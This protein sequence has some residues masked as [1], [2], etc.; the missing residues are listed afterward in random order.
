MPYFPA[1][2]ESRETELERS[3]LI[4]FFKEQSDSSYQVIFKMF[5]PFT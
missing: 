2:P 4:G 3:N 5:K 1:G